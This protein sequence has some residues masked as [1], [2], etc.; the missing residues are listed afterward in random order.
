LSCIIR[1]HYTVLPHI[2]S[3]TPTTDGWTSGQRRR[4]YIYMF[5]RPLT[6]A[7]IRNVKSHR[8]H[9]STTKIVIVTSWTLV[10]SD[11]FCTPSSF[12][13][14]HWPWATLPIPTLQSAT[15]HRR[16]CLKVLFSLLLSSPIQLLTHVV[17]IAS[18]YSFNPPPPP[19]L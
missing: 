9:R 15:Q 4:R 2:K 5:S 18:C 3:R 1:R 16:G 8:Q 17:Q 13:I 11:H 12:I 14:S 7:H 19:L 10:P 6:L